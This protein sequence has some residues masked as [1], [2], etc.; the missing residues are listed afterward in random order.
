MRFIATLLAVGVYALSTS[1]HSAS[2]TVHWD[3]SIF[4]PLGAQPV[5]FSTDAGA[6]TRNTSA[7]RF[8]GTVTASTLPAGTF[9]DSTSD[10]WAY[11]ADLAQFLSPG[12]TYQYTVGASSTRTLDWLGAVNSVLGSGVYAWLHPGNSQAAAAIQL[13]IWESIYDAS[14]WDLAAGSFRASGF[15]AGTAAQYAAFRAAVENSATADLSSTYVLQLV[16]D[17]VQDVI[18]GRRLTVPEPASLLL[19]GLGAAVAGWSSRRKR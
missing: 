1:V 18:S 4:A 17:N 2:V 6:H 13:G 10:F 11:C 19:F 16:N 9:V 14:G 8:Q 7:G 3:S 15:D 5:T 12:G